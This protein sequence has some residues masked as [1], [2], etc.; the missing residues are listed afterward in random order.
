M[1]MQEEPLC[2]EITRDSNRHYSGGGTDTKTVLLRHNGCST[3][4]E[5][6]KNHPFQG[7]INS[8]FLFFTES[9][10]FWKSNLNTS[11]SSTLR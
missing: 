8:H 6:F 10:L 4:G 11:T 7:R 9:S 3:G 2:L 1:N 5:L